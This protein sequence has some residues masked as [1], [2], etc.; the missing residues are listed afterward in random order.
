VLP[1]RVPE[2]VEGRDD[3]QGGRIRC[4]RLC[5]SQ[6]ERRIRNEIFSALLRQLTAPHYFLGSPCLRVY[7]NIL[8]LYW[9]TVTHAL[10]HNLDCPC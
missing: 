3:E 10:H 2:K 5:A 1:D 6:L 8:P 7:V 4:S 9:P